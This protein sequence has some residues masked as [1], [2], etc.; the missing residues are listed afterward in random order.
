MA[1][2]AFAAAAAALLALTPLGCSGSG[3]DKAGGREETV[4]R[5]LG[6]P[7]T[8]SLVTVDDLWSSEFAAAAARLSG[9]SIRIDV[10]IGGFA[11]I[12]YERRLVKYVLTGRADAA[13]VGARVWDTMGVTSLRGLVAPFLVDSLALERRVVESPLARRALRGVEPLGLVGLAVLPG[14]LRRPLGVSG[15]LVAAQ[16]YDGATIGIRFGNVARSTLAALGATAKGYRIG[17]LA[18]VDGAELDVGTIALARYAEQ[19]HEL[20]SNVVLWPRPETIVISR[21][22]FERL[23]P[24]Q[25]ETLRRAGREAI[26]SVATRLEEEQKEALATVCGRGRLSLATASASELARLHAAV[27][28]VYAELERDPLSRELLAQTRAWRHDAP[29]DVLRCPAPPHGASELAGVWRKTATREELLAAG[30]STA[31]AARFAGPETVELDDGRWVWRG[32]HTTVTGTYV[33]EGNAIRLTMRTCTANP[34]YPRAT[35]EY[36]WSVY[37]DTLT[38]ARRPGRRAWAA[39]LVNGA[40]RVR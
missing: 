20:T 38:F 23:T 37:R 8:L 18:E 28:P 4:T 16:D 36:T 15:P 13:S 14:P 10:R 25:R 3:G 19:A 24:A 35:T 32:E 1:A 6:R 9:G 31:E 39:L 40:N 27:A 26:A 30:A 22:A 5:A 11:L 33:V 2:R 17:S 34:C 29:A 21:R 12:D 7:V